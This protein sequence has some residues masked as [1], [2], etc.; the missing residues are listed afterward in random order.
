MAS[1]I[2]TEKSLMDSASNVAHDGKSHYVLVIH[3]GAGT[4]SKEG[5]TPEQQR[6]YKAAL[7][8][9]LRSVS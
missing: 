3:G 4:M 8:Q 9:A 5:S 7:A 1:I 2:S 6:A